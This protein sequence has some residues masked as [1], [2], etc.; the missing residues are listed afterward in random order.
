ML[1]IP[2]RLVNNVSAPPPGIL[3]L[4][5]ARD[6]IRRGGGPAIRGKSVRPPGLIDPGKKNPAGAGLGP[7]GGAGPGGGVMR[8]HRG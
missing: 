3:R 4:P 6:S 5:E 7:K 1:I 8:G 2:A